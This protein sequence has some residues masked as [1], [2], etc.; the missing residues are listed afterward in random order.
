M[1]SSI[2]YP[3][4]TITP[5]KPFEE[6][7]TSDEHLGEIDPDAF[8]VPSVPVMKRSRD[9]PNCRVPARILLSLLGSLLLL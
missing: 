6:V 4:T 8:I 3:E 1:L 9:S 5:Y 7:K 2:Y